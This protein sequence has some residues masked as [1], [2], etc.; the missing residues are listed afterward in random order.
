MESDPIIAPHS[1]ELRS[2]LYVRIFQAFVNSNSSVVKSHY[3]RALGYF[4]MDVNPT[5]H[6]ANLGYV[7]EDAVRSYILVARLC[8]RAVR[9]P[10]ARAHHP[11]QGSGGNI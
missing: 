8:L 5:A 3:K 6:C 11:V 2:H 9:P 7:E 4:H 1:T 10:G